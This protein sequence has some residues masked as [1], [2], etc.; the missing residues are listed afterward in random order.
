MET[1]LSFAWSTEGAVPQ[2]RFFLL[3]VTK[4]KEIKPQSKRCTDIATNF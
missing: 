2:E 3:Q 4:P 1:K